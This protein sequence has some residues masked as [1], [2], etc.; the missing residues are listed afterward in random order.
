MG[1]GQTQRRRVTNAV[2]ANQGNLHKAQLG[3]ASRYLPLPNAPKA[4]DFKEKVPKSLRKLQILK[5]VAEKH[6]NKGPASTAKHSADPAR[7]TGAGEGTGPKQNVKDGAKKSTVQDSSVAA[8]KPQKLKAGQDAPLPPPDTESKSAKKK[9]KREYMRQKDAKKRNKVSDSDLPVEKEQEL[10]L[11]ANTAKFGEQAA[12]PPTVNLKRKHWDPQ[13]AQQA[14]SE[15]CQKL[16]VKQMEEAKKRASLVGGLEGGRVPH[17]PKLR[18]GER[19]A[20]RQKVIAAYR[21]QRNTV[22]TVGAANNDSLAQLV[23]QND[24]RAS[25]AQIR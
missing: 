8:E 12:A 1:K 15:R 7:S 5:A 18:A 4:E 14:S 6:N 22:Q 23:K 11:K 25:Q 13:A 17:K 9:R 16:F 19:E 24:A 10:L 20:L 3:K 2:K 21:Q